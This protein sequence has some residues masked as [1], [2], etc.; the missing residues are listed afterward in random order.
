MKPFVSFP[1]NEIKDLFVDDSVPA[2]ETKP[3]PISET[4][5][6]VQTDAPSPPDTHIHNPIQKHDTKPS[7]AP[8]PTT[9]SSSGNHSNHSHNSRANRAAVGTGEHLLR[10]KDKRAQASSTNQDFNFEDS[11]AAFDKDKVFAE[12]SN[13]STV[14]NVPKYSKDDF[15]D[16]LTFSDDKMNGKMRNSEERKLNM[17]TFG[18]SGNFHNHWK[19]RGHGGGRGRGGP[20]R[21]N[22]HNGRGSGR[23]NYHNHR[24]HNNNQAQKSQ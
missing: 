8:A 16:N 21:Y 1:G 12:I 3:L 14:D 11:T 7:T 10:S 9:S 19:G 23:S 18:Q 17:D 24:H 2:E 5:T 15:F 20:G 22:S 6:T 13:N 4:I